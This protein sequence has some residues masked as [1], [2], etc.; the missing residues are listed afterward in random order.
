MK[1]DFDKIIDRE[2]TA[3][4][5]W[6]KRKDVFGKEDIL[7][8]W[9]ADA[10]WPT[11]PKVV[12]AIKERVDHGVFGYSFP[13]EEHEQA[14]VS[15]VKNRYDWE[16]KPEWLIYSNGVVPSIEATIKTFCHRGDEVIIQPPVYYPFYT[17]IKNCGTQVANNMLTK[18]NGHYK[19][20]LDHLSSLLERGE[21]KRSGSARHQLLI[22]CSPHNPVGRVWTEKELNKLGKLT[23]EH[24]ITV[25]YDE[26]HADLVFYDYKHTPFVCLS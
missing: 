6:D 25:I 1:Y 3:C 8:M 21:G 23:T 11:S 22:L 10:D 16:I 4:A 15:W 26:I 18:E 24:D 7:P 2:N 17:A 9:V 5:K 13:D 19:M 14:V 12:K 20:D